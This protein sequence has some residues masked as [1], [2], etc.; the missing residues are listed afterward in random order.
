MRAR[1]LVLSAAA[2]LLAGCGRRESAVARGDR[3]QVLHRGVGYEVTVLDPQLATGIA[4]GGIDA[5]LFEGLVREDPRDLHPVPGAAQRWE[6]T[7][8]GTT[9]TFYLRPDARWS[10]GAPVTAADFVASWKRILSPALGADYASM[11]Y[12]LQ[13]AEA[14]NRGSISDFGQVGVAALGPR[15]LRVI[16]DHPVPDFLERLTHWAWSPVY[17]PAITAAGSAT[18]RANPWARPGRLVGNGAFVLKSWEPD[19]VIVLARSPTYWGAG[20]VRLREVRLYPIDSV[21]AEER[22]F[23]AGQLHITDALPVAKIDEYRREDPKVLRIDPYL[24]TYYYALN[25]R[26]PYLSNPLIRRALS[27]AIDRRALVE[28]ILRGGEAPAQ[29]FTPPGLAGYEPG[30]LVATDFAQARQLLARAGYAGGRGLPPFGLLYNNSEN[31]RLIAEAVQE[32]WKRELG[33]D[34]TLANEENKVVLAARQA[35]DFQIVRGDWIADYPSPSSFL[36][37][38]RGDNG[39]NFTGWSSPD[40]DSLLFAADRAAD[41][42]ARRALWRKAEAILLQAAPIIPIY[43]YTH[44]FLIQPSVRGWYPN[45]LDHHPYQDVWLDAAAEAGSP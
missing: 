40:Y 27:L 29:S 19:R 15:V 31:H 33:V 14:F 13:G 21:E 32:M 16:L 25:V 17:L 4:E 37:V 28:K 8:D 36:N 35:G 3:D 12:V 39:N 20:L 22:A 43:H 5:A 10:N 24:G 7:P 11:L 9:Y 23:R 42:A 18:D 6:V 30:E 26:R 41:P 38:W 34:V 2:L 44:V 45:F 1:G